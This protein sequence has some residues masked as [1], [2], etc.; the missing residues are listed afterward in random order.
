MVALAMD[1]NDCYSED[2]RINYI[3]LYIIDY[4]NL[5]RQKRKSSSSSIP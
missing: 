1:V 4:H 3:D 5:T 2:Q